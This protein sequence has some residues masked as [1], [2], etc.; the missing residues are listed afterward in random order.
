MGT[1]NE[2]SNVLH[3]SSA[4]LTPTRCH[5]TSAPASSTSGGAGV[6]T[7]LSAEPV[8]T[9]SLPLLQRSTPSML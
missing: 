2:L 3:H 8:F 1:V 5:I 6:R 7:M 9:L 4:S